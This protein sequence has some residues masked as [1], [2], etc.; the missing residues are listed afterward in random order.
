M[1]SRRP[2]TASSTAPAYAHQ[3]ADSSSHGRSTA[4]GSCPRSRSSVATRCQSHAL[5]PPPWTSANVAIAKLPCANAVLEVRDAWR[6]DRPHLLQLEVGA[7]PVEE[8]RTAAQH[9]RDHVQLKLVDQARRQVLVDDTGAPADH[10]VL[11]GRGPP[12][13]V[14]GRLDPLGYEG[15]R[16]VRERQ[17]LPPVMGEHEHRHV[18]RRLLTPPAGPLLVAP[19]AGPAAELP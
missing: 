15:E 9:Q 10:D 11:P 13:L 16:R 1:T 12:G 2:A 8:P 7:E 6:L 17:R 19:G 18:E 3:S 14:E 5:P 4:T